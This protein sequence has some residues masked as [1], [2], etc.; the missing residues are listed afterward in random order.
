MSIGGSSIGLSKGIS[1]V[2]LLDYYAAVAIIVLK[3]K[4]FLKKSVKCDIY[5]RFFPCNYYNL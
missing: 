5:H 3:V 4:N 2:V 1:F